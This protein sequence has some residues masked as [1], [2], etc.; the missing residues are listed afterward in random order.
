[1]IFS[2][3]VSVALTKTLI[4]TPV[5]AYL[6]LDACVGKGKAGGILV[7]NSMIFLLSDL[8][9]H[10]SRTFRG[11]GLLSRVNIVHYGILGGLKSINQLAFG[12]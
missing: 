2:L 12:V 10:P 11:L 3:H 9:F 4:P 7:R 5:T 8:F 1:M 6:L